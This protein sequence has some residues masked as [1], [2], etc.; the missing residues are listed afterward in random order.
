MTTEFS[1][2]LPLGPVDD[3]CIFGILYWC[4]DYE[5]RCKYPA[6]IL[7]RFAI[8]FYQIHQG[9]EWKDNGINKYESFAASALHFMMVAVRL[10]LPIEEFL[11]IRLDTLAQINDNKW[12]SVLLQH[13]SGAQQQ[14]FYAN[15]ANKTG[16][17]SRYNKEKLTKRL[18]ISI[19]TLIAIIPPTIRVDCFYA[20]ARIMTKEL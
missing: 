6:T 5:K 15:K 12:P 17:A 13:L 16:R 8:G 1:I 20:A 3:K 18:G 10:E 14:L 19:R 2:A 7:N 4:K 11:E 9:M